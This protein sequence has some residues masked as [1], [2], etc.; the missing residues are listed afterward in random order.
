MG[1]GWVAGSQ[2]VLKVLVYEQLGVKM[3]CWDDL[4]GL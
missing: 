4:Q 1:G 2:A 3:R